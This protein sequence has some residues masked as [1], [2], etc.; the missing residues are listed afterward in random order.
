MKV[1]PSYF[2]LS[3]IVLSLAGLF[4]KRIKELKEMQ[5]QNNQDYYFD[6]SKFDRA[7]QFTTTAYEKGI[8]QILAG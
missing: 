1:K 5:Y 6:A 2:T 8:E 3:S 7:F 4:S